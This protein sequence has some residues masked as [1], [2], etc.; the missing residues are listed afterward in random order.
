[1]CGKQV[2]LNGDDTPQILQKARPELFDAVNSKSL[3]PSLQV[4]KKK[5]LKNTR[6]VEFTASRQFKDSDPTLQRSFPLRSAA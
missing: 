5:T 3:M 1:M 4:W 2:S 6:Y